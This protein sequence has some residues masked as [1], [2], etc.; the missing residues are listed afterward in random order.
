M[1]PKFHQITHINRYTAVNIHTKFG[2]DPNF[3]T[4]WAVVFM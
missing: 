1:K 3:S 2:T 4:I